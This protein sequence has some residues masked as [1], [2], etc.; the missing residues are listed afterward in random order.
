M[1]AAAERPRDI[2]DA[3]AAI[4]A[5][6]QDVTLCQAGTFVYRDNDGELVV[7]PGIRLVEAMFRAWGNV[8]A[9]VE[10]IQATTTYSDVRSFAV[11]LE[12]LH[13]EE[14]VVQVRHVNDRGFAL[15]DQ[16]DVHEVVIGTGA[17]NKRACML[18]ILPGEFVRQTLSWVNDTLEG[19]WELTD[20]AIDAVVQRLAKHLVGLQHVEEFLGHSIDSMQASDLVKLLRIANS[21]DERATRPWDW[22][23]VER[24]KKPGRA[25]SLHEIAAE[26]GGGVEDEMTYH[27][28]EPP[29]PAPRPF[30]R[31]VARIREAK[32]PQALNAAANLIPAIADAGERSTLESA[33]ADQHTKLKDRK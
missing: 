22:F 3:F 16:R 19:E 31:L 18:A 2:E 25:R 13:S 32:D 12:T 26:A 33:V 5:A 14:R 17:K 30:E 8:S 11:D 9:G 15:V 29:P 20:A 21:L 27:V 24:P 1:R 10:V 4:L 6:V 28:E 7:A 23:K